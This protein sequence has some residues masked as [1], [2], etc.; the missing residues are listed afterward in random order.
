ML[1]KAHQ[2]G[3]L[4]T[5]RKFSLLQKLSPFAR[6]KFEQEYPDFLKETSDKKPI[7]IQIEEKK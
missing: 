1:L 5:E 6:N 2:S 3:N 7:E 4:T